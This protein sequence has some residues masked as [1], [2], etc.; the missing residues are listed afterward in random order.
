ME[1]RLSHSFDLQ[2]PFDLQDLE[3]LLYLILES[4]ARP[5]GSLEPGIGREKLDGSNVL[6]LDEAERN[7]LEKID[8][9]S[10]RRK[11]EKRRCIGRRSKIVET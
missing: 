10:V 7:R 8:E 5:K 11:E 4:L 3:L 9:W 2:L 6:V 1:F